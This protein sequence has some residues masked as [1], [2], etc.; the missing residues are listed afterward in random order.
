MKLFNI[1]ILCVFLSFYACKSEG[2]TTANPIPKVL[3]FYKTNGFY[4][5][6]IPAG[7]KAILTLGKENNFLVDTTNNADVFVPDSLKKY[8]AVVFFNTTQDVL[9]LKQQISFEKYIQA[10]NGFVGIHSATDTEYN[11]PWY[12]K[13]VG[14][15]FASHS[16]IQKGT[17]KVKIK[18]HPATKFLGETW[19]REDEWYNFK[20]VLPDL[21]VLIEIDESSY[22][23]GTHGEDH[24][25]AWY[26]EYDGGRA[27]YTAGGHTEESYQDPLFLKHITG[28]IAYALGR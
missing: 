5:T 16:V 14:A 20:D 24:P 2:N 12:H 21:M 7:L 22:S 6:S 27:F 11:W 17:L 10:G 1:C 19:E 3:V 26:H 25:I 28:G 8:K 18:D 9:D 15:Y 4:H 23:G 13:L